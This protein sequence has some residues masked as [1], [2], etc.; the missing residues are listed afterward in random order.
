[1]S[2]TTKLELVNS[3]AAWLRRPSAVSVIPDWITLCEKDMQRRLK[4]GDQEVYGGTL[5]TTA[6]NAIVALPT[7]F[8]KMRRL[9][10]IQS[11]G[12]TDLWPVSLAPSDDQNVNFT[13]PPRAVSVDGSN[14][15][16]RPI[17]DQAYTLSIDY[18][19][20][21]TPLSTDGSTNW[22]LTDNPDAYLYGTL[23]H[24][25]PYLG[26]DQRLTLWEN[27]YNSAIDGINRADFEKRFAGL[28]RQTE[29]AM[30]T[31]RRGWGYNINRGF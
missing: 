6:D 22:I 8:T 1:L 7:G 18:Y 27:A 30:L 4:V 19:A 20:K 21:F 25:A 17:P 10:L 12:N 9:R 14:L 2:I 5:T 28:Q 15:S 24:S 3:V 31:T 16:I 11:W 29:T 26:T 23:M 13:G